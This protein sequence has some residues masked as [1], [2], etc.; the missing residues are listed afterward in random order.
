M[1]EKSQMKLYRVFF[2]IWLQGIEKSHDQE[3]YVLGTDD[4]NSLAKCVEANSIGTEATVTLQVKI[5]PNLIDVQTL[6]HIAPTRTVTSKIIAV[7]I[8]EISVVEGVNWIDMSAL[9][10]AGIIQIQHDTQEQEQ[11]DVESDQPNAFTNSY[12]QTH[13][14]YDGGR[15]S[16]DSRED[17][18]AGSEDRES[19]KA[20]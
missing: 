9:D 19:S 6:Q 16:E 5:P 10:A 4:L 15:I 2:N 17:Q 1:N 12:P 13:T 18:G 11:G 8:I 14:I 7:E 3:A 20:G